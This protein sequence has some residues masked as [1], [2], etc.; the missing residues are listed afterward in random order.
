M[1]KLKAA[2]IVFV[3]ILPFY[4]SISAYVR[5]GNFNVGIDNISVFHGFSGLAT[6]LEFADLH[7]RLNNK[8]LPYENGK[9]FYYNLIEPLLYEAKMK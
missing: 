2:A 4:F 6:S 9:Q 5:D 1:R 7:E 3:I 8:E